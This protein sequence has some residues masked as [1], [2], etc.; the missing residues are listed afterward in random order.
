MFYVPYCSRAWALPT[1]GRSVTEEPKKKR[2]KRTS[3]TALSR[4]YLNAQGWT[5]ESCE[6]KVPYSFIS[7][8]TFCGDLLGFCF[9]RGVALFQV[10]SAPNLANRRTKCVEHAHVLGWVRS[11]GKFFLHAW[12]KR[13]SHIGKRLYWRLRIEEI[14][15]EQNQLVT[16]QV[17]TC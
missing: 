5:V 17:E 11:G 13:R 1:V 8:D 3:M 7:Q 9:G 4:R 12:A 14:I 2:K 16:R 6:K 10:T 15:I